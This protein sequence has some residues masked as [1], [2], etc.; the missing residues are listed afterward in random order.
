MAFVKLL[1]KVPVLAKD[2]AAFIVNPL[3]S[4]F[5]LDAMRAAY[6]AVY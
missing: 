4:P 5:V 1:G 3:L 6:K 2:Q